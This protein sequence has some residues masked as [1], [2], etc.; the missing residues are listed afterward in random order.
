MR[1]LAPTLEGILTPLRP[2]VS[3]ACSSTSIATETSTSGIAAMPQK[4]PGMTALRAGHLFIPPQR[5]FAAF[6]GR[7]IGKVHGKWP[8]RTH[9]AHV[10]PEC[11]H[12]FELFVEIEPIPPR[13]P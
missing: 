6:V 5:R 12:V 4:R 13:R 3:T 1:G 10:M 8:A 7:E 11:A 9:H 2:S